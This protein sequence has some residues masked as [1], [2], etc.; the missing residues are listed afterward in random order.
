M[1]DQDGQGVGWAGGRA[2]LSRRRHNGC[3]YAVLCNLP[4][5]RCRMV[6]GREKRASPKIESSGNKKRSTALWP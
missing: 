4:A 5:Q 3:H 1:T 6:T 2:N